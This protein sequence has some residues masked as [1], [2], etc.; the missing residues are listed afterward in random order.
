MLNFTERLARE[1]SRAAR[2]SLPELELALEAEA[3]SNVCRR[4]ALS[5]AK[6][7]AE[8]GLDA[9]KM[10]RELSRS[11]PEGEQGAPVVEIRVIP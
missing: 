7:A 9:V 3:E 11:E 10:I 6:R 4:T 8:G 5:L 2:M 1:V